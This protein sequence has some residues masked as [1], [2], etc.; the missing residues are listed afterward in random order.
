MVDTVR[1]DFSDNDIL[2]ISDT[3]HAWRGQ[4]NAIERRG[5]Y[6]DISGFCH[7]A[8]LEDIESHGYVLTPGRFVG[9]K[10]EV[11]DGVPF[12]EKFDALT[13]KLNTQFDISDKLQSEIRTIS[14]RL[15]V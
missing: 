9:A 11:D 5:A 7:S 8:N 1:R 2:Q 4:P 14:K 3:Y 12:E 15:S 10:D 13:T 6:E